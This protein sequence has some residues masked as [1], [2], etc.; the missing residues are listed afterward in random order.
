MMLCRIAMFDWDVTLDTKDKIFIF[1]KISIESNG[2]I[3]YLE[4]PSNK[5]SVDAITAS[6]NLFAKHFKS[7][8]K[9]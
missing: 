2:I 5:L 9:G 1:K 6:I 3:L 7:I 8:I 4:A